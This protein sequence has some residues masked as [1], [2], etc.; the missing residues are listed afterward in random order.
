MQCL[1]VN[2][3]HLVRERKS[4]VFVCVLSIHSVCADLFSFACHLRACTHF[5]VFRFTAL[6][7]RGLMSGDHLLSFF[8][9]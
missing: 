4:L 2:V 3:Y 5:V 7:T 8:Q 6:G 9:K 1:A